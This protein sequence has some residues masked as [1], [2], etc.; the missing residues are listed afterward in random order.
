ME[1]GIG[2]RPRLKLFPRNWWVARESNPVC[3]EDARF[4][5]WCSR[6]C[7]SPPN[8]AMKP[9]PFHKHFRAQLAPGI[10]MRCQKRLWNGAE[11]ENRTPGL[12]PYRDRALPTELFPQRPTHTGIAREGAIP[13]QAEPFKTCP[14]CQ[15]TCVGAG[16]SGRRPQTERACLRVLLLYPKNKKARSPC[17][18]S[19]PLGLT[20]RSVVEE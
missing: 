12:N 3:P 15:R 16:L 8:D 17:G 11:R 9:S 5:V 2:E 19:E 13:I 18:T 4:T 1:T 10:A 7:C 20:L 14:N 6:L